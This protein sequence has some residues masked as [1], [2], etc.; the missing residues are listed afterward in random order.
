MSTSEV[1]A[2]RIVTQ[3]IGRDILLDI[4]TREK[5]IEQMMFPLNI[6]FDA[7]ER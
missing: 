5:E 7:S 6:A 2:N 3:N 4:S 1:P